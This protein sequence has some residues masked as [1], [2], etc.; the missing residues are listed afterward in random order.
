MQ[1]FSADATVFKK[2]SKMK[3][4]PSKVAQKYSNCFSLWAAKTTQTEIVI[5]QNVAYRPTVHKTGAVALSLL[6]NSAYSLK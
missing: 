4:P 2:K 3:K 5:F 1:L 6:S